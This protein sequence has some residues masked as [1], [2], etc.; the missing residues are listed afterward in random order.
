MVYYDKCRIQFESDGSVGGLGE[1][2]LHEI[3]D[4]MS[5]EG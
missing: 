2:K 4:Y 5:R 3:L 1:G